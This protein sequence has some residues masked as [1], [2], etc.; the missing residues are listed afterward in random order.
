MKKIMMLM[1]F[2]LGITS[3][4]TDSQSEINTDADKSVK[5]SSSSAA[6]LNYGQMHND[7]LEIYYEDYDY[8]NSDLDLMEGA[9]EEYL[10]ESSSPIT[11]NDVKL[12]NPNLQSYSQQLY[13]TEGNVS[14]IKDLFQKM[15]DDGLSSKVSYDYSIELIEIFEQYEG[16]VDAFKSN[17]NLYRDK[18]SQDNLI[19]SELKQNLLRAINIAEYS[20]MY[21]YEIV[22]I[23]SLAKANSFYSANKVDTRKIVVI[24][25]GDVAGALT[26]IQSGLVGYASL[27]F[28]PWG[29]AIAMAGTAAIGS[30]NAARVL[31]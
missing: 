26:G 20:H 11:F 4:S 15:Y 25:G 23:N 1:T 21:W 28:G 8:A 30:L 12:L 5:M 19:D 24:A 29:G 22:N 2:F 10:I 16:D 14:E 3:C 27:V 18:V 6:G 31:R 9:V 17:I 13:R 7:I